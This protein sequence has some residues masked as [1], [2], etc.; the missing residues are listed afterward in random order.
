[1]LVLHKDLLIEM[2]SGEV[3]T[4]SAFFALLVV[5]TASLS[6]Y[7]GPVTKQ[8]VAAGV[9]WLSLAFA[10]VLALSRT[11]QR[12]R[13]EGALDGLLSSPVSRSAVFAGKALGVWVFILVVEAVVLPATA[14]FFSLD[15]SEFG[16]GLLLISLFATPGL[17]ATGTLF[18]A[19]TVRTRARDLILAVVLF[20]LLSPTL[21]AAVVATRELLNQAQ[22]WELVDYFKLM[23]VFDITFVSG[24][25][26]LFGSL[27]EG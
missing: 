1:M 10:T 19:M 17:A 3:L 23:V 8:L 2:R 9:L 24:G 6:F 15:L 16:L 27:T 25:L 4:T 26:A 5:I 13:D 20:P 7:G 18:G 12:E 11:W 22:V 14:L 21:L